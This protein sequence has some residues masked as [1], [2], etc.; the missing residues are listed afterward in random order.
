MVADVV[1]HACFML[2]NNETSG[3]LLPLF[4]SGGRKTRLIKWK[5]PLHYTSREKAIV[6][7]VVLTVTSLEGH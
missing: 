4:V 7:L 5:I 3:R 1:K 2:W 6:F